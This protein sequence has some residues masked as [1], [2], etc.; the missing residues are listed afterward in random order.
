MNRNKNI[1]NF[2]LLKMSRSFVFVLISYI[3]LLTTVKAQVE[4]HAVLDSNKI[5]IGEQTRLDLYV[6]YDASVNKKL[7]IQW[8]IIEDTL[9]KEI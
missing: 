4:V 2:K 3:C 7:N 5:R 1:V 8:P 6:R 9:K